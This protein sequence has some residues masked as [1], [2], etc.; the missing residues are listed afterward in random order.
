MKCW[1]CESTES[2]CY[3]DCECAKCV[4]PEAYEEWRRDNPEEYSSW[5]DRKRN[6]EDDEY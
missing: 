3:S 1:S 6:E 5:V 2:Y 4:D